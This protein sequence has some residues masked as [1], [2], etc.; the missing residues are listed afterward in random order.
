[1]IIK[2]HIND[3]HVLKN[4]FVNINKYNCHSS[5]SNILDMALKIIESGR[6]TK[7]SRAVAQAFIDDEPIGTHETIDSIIKSW[8]QINNN[9]L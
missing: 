5:T 3:I 2:L 6:E 8:S 7:L 9:I 1:M 4:M